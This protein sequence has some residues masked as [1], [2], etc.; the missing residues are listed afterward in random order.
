MAEIL[1]QGVEV[2]LYT[3]KYQRLDT[4]DNNT[5]PFNTKVPDACPICNKVQEPKFINAYRL[6]ESVIEAVFRCSSHTCGHIFISLHLKNEYSNEYII[7][8]TYPKSPLK[9][10][11][12]SYINNMSPLFVEIYNQANEAEERDLLHIAGMGYRKSLEFL[13]KDYLITFKKLDGDAIRK[14]FLGTCIKNHLSDNIKQ[15]AER[16]TW[17][18]N[19]E[20]HYHRV[21]E[22]MDIKDLKALID[23]TVY[24]ISSEIQTARYISEMENRR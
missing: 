12:N 6:K 20:T 24:Y 3:F 21:W 10:E 1:I 17:L 18:G 5:Y 4:N 15:V 22:A 2:R 19:D 13:I 16:A 14:T 8:L 9:K 23:L 11:F 7:K